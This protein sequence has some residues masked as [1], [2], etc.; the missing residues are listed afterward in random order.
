MKGELQESIS[1]SRLVVALIGLTLLIFVCNSVFGQ[2]QKRWNIEVRPSVNIA[3]QKA[4][5]AELNTG[6]GAEAT[7]GYLLFE[8]FG[9][10]GGWS[11]NKFDANRSFAGDN[12]QFTE[13]GYS[14][15]LCFIHS[16]DSSNVQFLVRSGL[17]YSEIG[18]NNSEG[19]LI[20]KTKPG[21]GWQVEA[22][23]S[24]VI[25]SNFNLVPT[26]RFHTLTR[27]LKIGDSSSPI[28]LKYVSLG[29]G[30]QWRF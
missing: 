19:N 12:V 26:V 9:V 7:V 24:F 11:W 4:G 2:T 28:S 16:F 5:G 14:L 6:F 17:V 27:D 13:S 29:L 25:T 1:K 20:N 15:G 30:G 10:Y 18:L 21:L 3:N 23:F 22:G 8:N